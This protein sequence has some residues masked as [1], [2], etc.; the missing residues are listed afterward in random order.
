[1]FN[2]KIIILMLRGSSFSPGLRKP[3]FGPTKMPKAREESI[4]DL[5]HYNKKSPIK[6]SSPQTILLDPSLHTEIYSRSL[7]FRTKNLIYYFIR[8]LCYLFYSSHLLN[9]PPG[10]PKCFASISKY[11][12]LLS[13]FSFYPQDVLNQS[14]LSIVNW[15]HPIYKNPLLIFKLVSKMF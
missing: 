5:S 15:Y 8:L 13:I 2:A 3:S 7:V 12:S 9:I 14:K 1:M 4:M 11:F 10:N 6:H